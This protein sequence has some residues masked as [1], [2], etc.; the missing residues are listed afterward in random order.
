MSEYIVGIDIG[1]TSTKAI[2]YDFQGKIYGKHAVGYPLDA[3]VPGA[4]VQDPDSIFQ[5]VITTVHQ[6]IA[7]SEIP[8]SAM[9]C[10]AF[11]AAMHSLIIVDRSGQLLTPSLTWADNRSA[12]WAAKLKK[13]PQGQQIY[14]RT[15]TPIHPM[16]PLSKLIWLRHEH[17]ELWQQADKFISI[18]E[19][20]FWQLFGEYL[21]DYSIASATGLFNLNNLTWDQSALALTEIKL[22]QLSTPVP[23]TKV[24]RGIKSE[25]AQQMGIDADTP[26]VIG[27]NDGV[28]ANLGVGAIA[29]GVVAVTVGTSGAVRTTIKQPQT[30]PQGRLFCYALTEN[31][32]VLGGAVNNGGITLRWVKEQLADAEIDTA[33]LLGQDPYDMLTAIASNIPPGSEG[34][35]FHPYLVGERAPLWDANARGSFFGLAWHHHKGHLIRAVLE[36]V[37]YNLYLVLEA[38]QEVTGEVNTI[39]AAGGFARSDLWRQMLADIFAQDVYIPQ[40]YESSCWGAA[41]LGMYAMNIIDDLTESVHF[42]NNLNHH[43]PIEEH[44]KIYRQIL[45]IYSRLLTSFQAEYQAIA[46]LQNHVID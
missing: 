37:V 17:P 27:A 31:Y 20:I 45:P 21:V 30:D 13:D 46:Q 12:K 34:L 9:V 8:A 19:Y 40:S 3:P 38:L 44:V 5:A 4:A 11:S 42:P 43:Q 6:A 25:F 23:T 29:P 39:K 24:C 2:V 36:G 15:G 18:K 28:L 14:T 1:T 33:K 35:I 41:I 7:K 10:L 16:S 32:W 22:S 26:V